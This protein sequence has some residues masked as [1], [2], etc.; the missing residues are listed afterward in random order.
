M[1]R[2]EIIT[3]NGSSIV[4]YTG[5]DWNRGEYIRL[6]GKYENFEI[7]LVLV[8]LYLRKFVFLQST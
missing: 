6:W 5:E 1:E 3:E 2:N 7:S 8:A 4:M